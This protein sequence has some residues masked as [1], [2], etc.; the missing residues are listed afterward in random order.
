ML[1]LKAWPWGSFLMVV[2]VATSATILHVAVANMVH[3]GSR[4]SKDFIQLIVD[5]CVFSTLAVDIV[6]LIITYINT[7]YFQ[8]VYEGTV[9]KAI[10]GRPG[11]LVQMVLF[12]LCFLVTVA[13]FG[14]LVLSLGWYSFTFM[15]QSF[16]KKDLAFSPD[17]LNSLPLVRDIA[18]GGV[19]TA[20]TVKQGC[21]QLQSFDNR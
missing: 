2:I 5:A 7:H 21:A 13:S 14:T 6:L 17:V 8:S 11:E 20:E 3:V 18:P 4:S 12:F 16:C 1:A 9:V 15:F 10:G 19:W